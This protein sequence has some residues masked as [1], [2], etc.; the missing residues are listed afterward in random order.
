MP[1][2]T[3]YVTTPIYYVNAKPHIGHAYT[4]IVCDVMKRFYTLAGCD[5]YFTTGTDEHGAKVAQAAAE[6]GKTPQQYVDEISALFQSTWRDFDIQNDCFIRTTDASHVEVVQTILKRVYEAGDI[7]FGEYEGKYCFGCERFYAD[8]ELVDGKCPDHQTA[9]TVI[10]EKNYLFRMSK[11]RD[12]LVDH[13]RSNPD[14]IRP[15]RY[16]NEVLSFLNEPLRDLC[17]SR[18]KEALDWGIELPFD[19]GFVTYVWFDALINYISAIGYPDDERFAKYWPESN[20][21]TAKDILKPHGVYWPIMLKSAGIAPY[22]HLNVHGYWNMDEAKMSKSLGNVANPLQLAEKY[23]RDSFRYYLL[24][25]MVFGLDSDFSEQGLAGRRNNDLGNDFGNLVYRVVNMVGRFAD[26]RVPRA[27]SP[28]SGDDKLKQNAATMRR[29]VLKLVDERHFSRAL[30]RIW[31]LV[32]LANGYVEANRPWR[33]AKDP[34]KAPVLRTVLYNLCEVLRILATVL[35]AFLPDS[36]ARIR[37]QLSLP[38]RAEEFETSLVWGK[39]APEVPVRKD[40]PLF[41]RLEDR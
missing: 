27:D 18:P 34:A 24:R 41:P 3:F 6:E 16:R 7:Y 36:C 23:G 35:D 1:A 37:A 29:D 33:L 4:T 31:E 32:K 14:F 5:A 8:R 30:E 20:H 25:D 10:R 21:F 13:I 17:I 19:K 15:E 9:P 11:Y 22:K 26:G 40:E 2:K 38:G 39:L 12:W 28:G